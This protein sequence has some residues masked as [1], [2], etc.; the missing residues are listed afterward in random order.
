MVVLEAMAA[1]LPVV[2]SEVEGI[3]EAIRDGSDGLLFEAA[4]PDQLA[5]QIHALKTDL[6]RWEQMGHSAR[7]R[8]RERLSD[9]AMAA[10]VSAVYQSL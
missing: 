5:E 4:N 8:H 10:N 2:A 1:G 3:P 7:E 9:V 6:I